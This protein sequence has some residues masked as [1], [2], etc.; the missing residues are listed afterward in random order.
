MPK[1]TIGLHLVQSIMTSPG[2]KPSGTNFGHLGGW[3][4]VIDFFFF[5]MI[6]SFLDV[7]RCKLRE[8][9]EDFGEEKKNSLLD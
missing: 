8:F 6:F 3:I 4:P 2:T 5:V 7:S 9:V 1:M